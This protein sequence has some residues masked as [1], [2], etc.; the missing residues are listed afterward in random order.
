MSDFPIEVVIIAGCAFSFILGP[1]LW[2]AHLNKQEERKE[3]RE[4][5]YELAMDK[6]REKHIALKSIVDKL[7][8]NRRCVN[9]TLLSVVD[10][11][12]ELRV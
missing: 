7:E 9:R 1:M 8:S 5:Q 4:Q 2:D 6:A 11:K 12:G 10:I 3:K